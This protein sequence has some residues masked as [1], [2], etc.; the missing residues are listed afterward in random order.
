LSSKSTFSNST[1]KSYAL[2]L[3]EISKENSSLDKSEYEMRNLKQLL[4]E[5]S[6]F[7]EMILNPMITKESKQSVLFKIAEQNNFSLSSKKFLGFIADKNRLFFL[8]KIIESFLSLVSNNKGELSAKLVSSKELTE[9]EKKKIQDQL[10][11]DFKSPLN[12]DYKH[13]PGLIG[14][15]IIQIGSIMIDASIKNKLKKLETKMVEA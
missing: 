15:L 9:E 2:A 11:S 13:D 7:K 1:S 6:D 14:G 4:H 3:Y 12:I 8:E 10:S 5:S